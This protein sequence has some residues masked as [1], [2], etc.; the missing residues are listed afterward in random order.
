MKKSKYII[1][2]ITIS[3]F[4]F[5]TMLH[6]NIIHLPLERTVQARYIDGMD[7]DRV[8]VGIMHNIFVAKIINKT[9]QIAAVDAPVMTQFEAEVISNIKGLLS[10]RIVIS[11]EGGYENGIL[12]T[13]EGQKLLRVGSTYILS[14]RTDGQG[15]YLVTSYPRGRVLLTADTTLNSDQLQQLAAT[16]Q[17][18]TTLQE[19]YSHEIPYQIDVDN[20][21]N[22]NAYSEQTVK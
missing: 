7:N 15:T 6:E 14:A 18:V 3:L 9:G 17:D 5:A 2:T 22:L 1:A 4:A 11:Q 16:N 8:F 10:G 20:N 12:V 21:F 19:A 13:M